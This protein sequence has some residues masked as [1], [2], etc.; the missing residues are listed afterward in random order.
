M[1]RIGINLGDVIVE[2]GD[3][4]GEGVNIAARLQAMAMPGGICLSQTI[5]DHV[6]N[7]VEVQF[8]DLGERK[9][10]NLDR[11]VRVYRV[12]GI[13]SELERLSAILGPPSAEGPTGPSIAVLPFVNLSGDTE[14]NYSTTASPRTSSPA[15]PDFASFLSSLGTPHSGIAT[16]SWMCAKWRVSSVC[17][18]SSKAACA[19]PARTCV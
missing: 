5:V 10:K 12:V 16:R 3:L 19:R 7:K 8:E 6:R 1:L 18:L 15:F 4:Y 17:A 14:Q 13:A 11:P 9:L 2:G